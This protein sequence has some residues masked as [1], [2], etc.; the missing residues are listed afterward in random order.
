[1]K[2]KLISN[3]RNSLTILT[4]EAREEE[5]Q[6]IESKISQKLDNGAS[7]EEAVK[8]LGEVDEILKEIYFSR[9]IDASK[10]TKKKGFFYGKF[11]EL[12]ESIHNVVDVM[13]KNSFRDNLK[14]FWD[15]L[16]TRLNRYHLC[17]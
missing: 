17:N 13:A 3:L 2:E 7:E 4:N 8:S 10:I 16:I 1:M 5:I 6:K 15:I 14:I 12:F 9:G 11:E